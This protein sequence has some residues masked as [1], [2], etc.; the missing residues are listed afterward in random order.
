MSSLMLGVNEAQRHPFGVPALLPTNAL[1]TRP[2]GGCARDTDLEDEPRSCHKMFYPEPS[3]HQLSDIILRVC[4][5]FTVLPEKRKPRSGAE[6]IKEDVERPLRVLRPAWEACPGS[7]NRVAVCL[8]CSGIIASYNLQKSTPARGAL[9]GGIRSWVRRGGEGYGRGGPHIVTPIGTEVWGVG[10][11]Q[12][13]SS[14]HLLLSG[15]RGVCRVMAVMSDTGNAA[16]RP[17]VR[18]NYTPQS[19]EH[20]SL[21]IL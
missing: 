1:E 11:P 3:V 16:G 20:C 5:I 4:R 18:V 7:S 13:F 12:R 17:K 2:W 21:R 10:F 19:S 6:R 8:V 14:A 15:L 9:V